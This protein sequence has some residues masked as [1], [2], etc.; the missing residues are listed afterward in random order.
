MNALGGLFFIFFEGGF[1]FVI[2]VVILVNILASSY[3]FAIRVDFDHCDHPGVILASAARMFLY[4]M[5]ITFK[6]R[7]DLG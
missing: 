7:H 2:L 6:T 1:F 5:H 4:F 3:V